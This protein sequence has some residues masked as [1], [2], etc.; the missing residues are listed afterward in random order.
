MPEMW[1]FVYEG[2]RGEER[3]VRLEHPNGMMARIE[4]EHGAERVVLTTSHVNFTWHSVQDLPVPVARMERPSGAVEHYVGE[5]GAERVARVEFP[6]G[7]MQHYVG[8]RGRE[9]LVRRERPRGTVC[10]YEAL[11]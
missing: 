8:E 4:E 5:R 9:R 10:H 11:Q 7:A 6:S 2:E 1:R 3:L